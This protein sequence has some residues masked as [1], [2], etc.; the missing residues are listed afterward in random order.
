MPGRSVGIEHRVQ[1]VPLRLRVSNF[2]RDCV[3]NP[4]RASPAVLTGIQVGVLRFGLQC[5][6]NLATGFVL[7]LSL[8]HTLEFPTRDDELLIGLLKPVSLPSGITVSDVVLS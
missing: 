5:D 6:D 4:S 1:E 7:P 8:P 2:G 3:Q